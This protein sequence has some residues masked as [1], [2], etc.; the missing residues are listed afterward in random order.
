MTDVREDSAEVEAVTAPPAATR[1]P[2][3]I[4]ARVHLR[5]GSL[6]LA[7]VELETLAGRGEL[8]DDGIRD[9]AE[10]R[11]RTGDIGG[12]GDAA[13]TYL[14]SQPD[15]IHGLVIAAEA[16]AAAGRPGEARKLA[17][18]AIDRA[19]G[20]L[21]PIFAGMPRASIWPIEPGTAAGPAGVLFDDLHPGPVPLPPIAASDEEPIRPVAPIDGP[22]LWGDG[23]PDGAAAA[24]VDPADAG[25]LFRSAR[26]ALDEGRPADGA[27]ALLLALRAS[28]AIAPAVLDL[29]AGR[30]EPILAVV[31]GDAARI[32]GH[33]VDAMRDHATA[34][35]SLDTRSPAPVIDDEPAFEM[36]TDDPPPSMEDS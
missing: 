29:L 3:L 28:P 10:A 13:T 17:G 7:R 30:S 36:T 8:D 31:R 22:S 12:A 33:E 24:G 16:Q 21:D 27:A 18:R 5:L 1:D 25:S 9:L 2:D 34:A 19:D 20:S 32:V 23:D 14:E 26:A 4:L 11:W 15:D 35:G 6:G